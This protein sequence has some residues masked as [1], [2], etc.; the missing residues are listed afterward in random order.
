MQFNWDNTGVGGN[1]NTYNSITQDLI[2]DSLAYWRD[3]LGVDGFRFDLASV[4]GNTCQHG[5]FNFDKTD[6]NN[7]LNR[8]AREVTPRPHDGGAGTDLI[9]EPWAVGGN[10]YQVGGFPAAWSEWNGKYRDTLRQSQNKMGSVPI[11]TGQLAD[12]FTGSASLYQNTGRKPWHSIN[13]IV[14]HDGF[15]HKDLYRC[16]SKNNTQAWPFG[17]SDG[18]SDNNDSW[19]QGG[20]VADQRKA[21]RNGLSLLMLSAGTPMLTGGDEYLRSISCNNNP[22]NLDSSANWLNYSWTADQSNF[23]AFSRGLIAFRKAH[24]ALRPQSFYSAIDNN[25]NVMEQHRWFKPDG[26][27]PDAAYFDDANHRAIAFRVDGTEFCDSASSIYV[28]YNAWQSS[29]NFKL[30]W[31]GSNKSW[32]RVTDTCPWAEGATQFRVPGSEDFIGGEGYSYGVCG[33]GVLLLIA[34]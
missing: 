20:I 33:R 18:G 21:A 8:I 15:T 23:N 24:P 5:C 9:A 13:F 26:L 22:Y 31:P 7:A 6:A 28:A 3:T 17:P 11:T 2:V 16:N 4:L 10:S 12:Y 32:Y 1:M 27:V 19:D 14:A 34:K 25:A 29:V 30:P